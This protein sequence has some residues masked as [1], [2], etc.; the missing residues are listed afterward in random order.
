MAAPANP[1]RSRFIFR[2][3]RLEDPAEFD[4]APGV[5][6]W[7]PQPGF[8]NLTVRLRHLSAKD[9]ADAVRTVLSRGIPDSRP[10]SAL[11]SLALDPKTLI[12]SDTS[13]RIDEAIALL[14]RLD[15][16]GR[17]ATI[18]EIP[19]ANLAPA[20][21]AV[22]VAQLAAK[23]E[24]AGG[25]KLVGEILPAASNAAVIVLA[26]EIT[27]PVWRGLV[28]QADHREALTTTAYLPRAF[29]VRDVGALI[30]QVAASA[31]ALP[32]DRFKVVV[33]EPTGTILV[34]ATA[35]QHERIGELMARLDAV[36][37]EARRPIRAFTVRHRSAGDLLAVLQRMI[38]A[39]ALTAEL[40]PGSAPASSGISPVPLPALVAP[41]LGAAANLVAPAPGPQGLLL[42]GPGP[43][44][45]LAA[46]GSASPNSNA[47]A[48]SLTA[49]D[50][51][52]TIIAIGEARLLAQLEALLHSLDTC[53]PQVMLEVILVTLSE[54]DS[55]SLGVE[56]Q[57]LIRDGNTAI[58]LSSLFGLSSVS[59]M[60][61]GQVLNP[62]AAAGLTGA[63]LRPGDFSV[64]LK[65]L[66][67]FGHGRAVSLPRVLVT[68]NQRTQFDSLVQEPYGVSFTQGNSNATNV[69]FG[70]TLDAGTKLTI[71][72]QIGG[73]GGQM[74]S[75]E[76][77]ISISS[78]GEQGR[79]GNLPPSR[80]VNSVQ[81][82]ATVPDGHT[83]IV[84]GLENTTESESTDQ[85]PILGDIP[86]LG[87]F[88]KN[89]STNRTRSRFFVLIH[90]SVLRGQALE[91]LRN[92]SAPALEQAGV[93]DG[94]PVTRPEVIR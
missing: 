64:V 35:S 56:L 89:Q 20:Q 21:I 5:E 37:G 68:N 18:A 66:Q 51:T 41:A 88:F 31:S 19:V 71:R 17:A 93:R 86:I 61:A 24:L 23:R 30:Q 44:L 32:D 26:P 92:I 94:W 12:I 29:G 25:E 3:A 73:G 46:R 33:E 81:G 87:N 57:Q 43:G 45:G 58:A 74:L 79:A 2:L 28:A 77:S 47:L 83:V 67:S 16:P 39:G 36:P 1:R 9:A 40:A 65:A 48:I 59:G 11:T 76:Y 82:L 52:N 53:Q 70:G 42:P 55:I 4:N 78:F 8:R 6:T 54:R 69:T 50:A 85:L 90:A 34:T 84:G 49:D 7:T 72:P 27:L 63:V 60:G 15:L 80:Q 13:A 91:A 75:L 10:L 38:A 22:A 14:Q 62:S